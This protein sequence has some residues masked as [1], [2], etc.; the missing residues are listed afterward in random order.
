M[1]ASGRVANVEA[2]QLDELR[3][4][5]DRLGIVVDEHLRTSVEGIWAAGDVTGRYQF[6]PIAQYQARVAVDDMF[7][8]GAPGAD[9]SVLPTSIFTEPELAGVGLTQQEAK[10]QG[11]AHEVVTHDVKHVQRSAYKDQ[12]RGLYKIVF[13][14]ATRLVLGLHVV[15]PGG[16]DIV[17]GLSLG[18]RLGATVDDLAAMHHVFPTFG[19]G[20]K[21]AAEQALPQPLEMAAICN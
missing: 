20:F 14:P 6:T 10:E 8:L 13:D 11:V 3:I 15:A 4:E 19:E 17:Q 5:H 21:A 12:T 1:I 9:Y 18:L 16:G 7:G 2:L